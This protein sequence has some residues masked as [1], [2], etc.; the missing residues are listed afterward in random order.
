MT[1]EN[2]Q[3]YICMTMIT[4]GAAMLAAVFFI[5]NLGHPDN[6]TGS[7]WTAT[8]DR[9]KQQSITDVA[10]YGNH[11]IA[12]YGDHRTDHSVEAYGDHSVE[13]YGNH[14]T[15]VFAT[16]SNHATTAFATPSNHATYGKA[17]HHH[18]AL[19]HPQPRNYSNYSFATSAS[20]QAMWRRAWGQTKWTAQCHPIMNQL[21]GQHPTPSA[22]LGNVP[23]A[24]G[25]WRCGATRTRNPTKHLEKS[26]NRNGRGRAFGCGEQRAPATKLCN[27]GEKMSMKL[28]THE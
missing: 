26:P 16:P 23:P 9:A 4:A 11:S 20:L 22:S 15:T 17:Q 8:G 2:H 1:Q 24:G 19:Q 28:P 7:A 12:T 13:A 10:T 5:F 27:P 18:T 21:E 25:K 14:A 6:S 3:D